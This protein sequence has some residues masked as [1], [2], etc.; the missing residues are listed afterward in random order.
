[1]IGENEKK[2]APW[3]CKWERKR[4]WHNKEESKI[5]K[6]IDDQFMHKQKA[7][8]CYKRLVTFTIKYF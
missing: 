5:S 3:K 7:K 8:F 2:N 1:M 6:S 4:D